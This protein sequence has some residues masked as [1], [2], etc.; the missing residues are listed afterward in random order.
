MGLEITLS[1][2][3]Q[4]QKNKHVFLRCVIWGWVGGLFMKADLLRKMAGYMRRIRG[5]MIKGHYRHVMKMP[6]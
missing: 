5:A 1:E 4:T 2:I 6:R 3:S